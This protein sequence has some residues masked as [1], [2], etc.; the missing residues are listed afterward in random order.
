MVYDKYP[1]L[2]IAMIWYVLIFN[3][4]YKAKTKVKKIYTSS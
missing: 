4:A 3:T 2:G 1:G